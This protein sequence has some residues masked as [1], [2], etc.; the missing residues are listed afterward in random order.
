MAKL[1]RLPVIEEREIQSLTLTATSAGACLRGRYSGSG[2]R[3]AVKLLPNL[4]S[5]R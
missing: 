3:V 2:R 4:L 1:D 5:H